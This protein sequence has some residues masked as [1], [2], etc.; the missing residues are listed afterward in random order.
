M[1]TIRK[2]LALKIDGEEVTVPE[3]TRIMEAAR[4][5]GID[6]PHYCY[7]PSLSIAGS[8]RLCV[9]EIEG[10]PKLALAC[11]TRVMDGMVVRTDSPKVE[12]ARKGILE[13]FLIN[14]PLDCPVCDRGG[15]CMLQR[16]AMD[17]GAP[18]CRTT[19]PRNRFRKPQFDALIDIERNRC[20]LCSRCV[21]FME[22]IAGEHALGVFGRGDRAHIG[23]FENRPIQNLFSGMVIDF[24]PVGTLTSKPFRFRART[25]ELQQ[26]QSSCVYCSSG[27]ATTLWM[28]AGRIYRVTPPTYPHEINFQLDYDSRAVICNQGR[29]GNDF[30]NTDQRLK[31]PRVKRNGRM[32]QTEWDEALEDVAQRLD[33]IR[34]AHGPESIGFIASSRATCEEMYLL[35]RLARNVVGT[36]NVDWRVG[37]ADATAAEAFSLAFGSSTG[38]IDEPDRYDVILVVN[39]DLMAQAP[40]TALKLKEAARTGL[41]NVFVL[42]HRLDDWLSRYAQGVLHYSIENGDRVLH[43]LEDRTAMGLRPLLLRGQDDVPALIEALQ[44]ATTGLIVYGLDGCSGLLADRL[45]RRIARLARAL[46]D[47][48]ETMP[49]VPERNAAGAF[50]TGCQPDRL[51]GHWIDSETQ[52]S[53]IKEA[54][55]ASPPE[56]AGLSAPAMF[57]AARKGRLHALYV[58][59]AGDFLGIPWL[60]AILSALDNLDLLVV[61]DVF[62]SPVSERADVV[63]PGAFFFEKEGTL[64]DSSGTPG[65]LS[66]GW[67]RPHGIQ[68]D[69]AV[70]D[71]LARKLGTT[72]GYTD[73]G[74]VFEEMMVLINPICPAKAGDLCATT[75]GDQS[76]IRCHNMP[77]ERARL[78]EGKFYTICSTYVPTCR[79]V[80]GTHPRP[81]GD[82]ETKPA[83]GPDES[84]SL[85]V[86]WSRVLRGNDAFGDRS[87]TMAPLRGEPWIEMHPDDAEKLGL[88]E[89]DMTAVGGGPSAMGRLRLSRNIAPGLVYVPQNWAGLRLGAPPDKLPEAVIVPMAFDVGE[90][91]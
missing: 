35:Q 42:D 47:G 82:V 49:V 72:F 23:T 84:D 74:A 79:L 48:W 83:G 61:H 24:C 54:W 5:L 33:T 73:V 34:A 18:D 11:E 57:E 88:Q 63:L 22:E 37:L 36:N 41:A 52:R 60:D 65:R 45:V 17:H 8:C 67:N 68:D 78:Q 14:H 28:R 4:K 2:T 81:I 50:L 32:I 44:K 26:V 30:V 38:Q 87:D 90:L 15:E 64:V 91:M 77:R 6:I 59:G 10:M 56:P 43:A 12:Q 75:E 76:P 20:V 46:G 55:G 29:F 51:P 9:V 1:S 80:A 39:A 19:E 40:V 3:G 66:K 21:R 27:C 86:I 25:W 89:G 71:V 85:R 7:H 58:L 31:K 62:E 13:L 70:L 69:A 16:Y 53:R